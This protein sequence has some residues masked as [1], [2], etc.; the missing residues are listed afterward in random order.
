MKTSELKKLSGRYLKI[1]EWSA[2][3]QCFVGTCPELFGGG[4][5][6]DN[7]AAVYRKLCE[8]VEDVL[9]SKLK[10]RD[11]LP[12]PVSRQ[13]FSGKFLLRLDPAL[14]K[15]IAVRAFKRGESLNVYCVKAIRTA[16][17]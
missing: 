4:V 7:E 16:A 9:T 5:H 13:K 8:A 14:H 12:K 17:G 3:D 10:H 1:V 15:A 6:G 11:I 2:E